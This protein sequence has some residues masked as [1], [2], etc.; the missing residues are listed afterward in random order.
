MKRGKFRKF[1]LLPAILCVAIGVTLCTA[2]ALHLTATKPTS[3]PVTPPESTEE[4]QPPAPDT[5][6][7]L[8]AVGDNLIHDSIYKQAANRTGGTGYDFTYCYQNIAP[9]IKEHPFAF[10]NQETLLSALHDPSNYPTFNSPQQVGDAVIAAGFNIVNHANNHMFDKG[11][12]GLQS[13]IEYWQQ[14]P[15]CL[16]GAYLNQQQADQVQTITKNGITLSFVGCTEVTN[17]LSL[18]SSSPL[19][20]YHTS[21]KEELAKKIADSKANSDLCIVAVHWGNEGTHS[22]TASQ[23]EMAQWLADQGVDVILGGHSHT[24]QPIEWLQGKNGNNTLCV[25]SLGNFISAQSDAINMLGGMVTL[26][27]T[28]NGA[29]GETTVTGAKF[30]A[31]VTHFGSRKSD[32]TVY[33]FVDYTRQLASAHGVRQTDSSFSYD[34]LLRHIEQV[35]PKAYYSSQLR[36]VMEANQT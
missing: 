20:Y 24:I 26:E 17:G 7:T 1:N 34:Y 18:P 5:T 21:K 10:I 8:V 30:D 23:Q 25:Y 35:I 12:S 22:L 16:T 9:Y 19:V 13:T 2:L 36:Q 31:L 29:T 11:A 15:V 27:F 6:A 32:I 3:A 4:Q 28:K 33:N 14:K